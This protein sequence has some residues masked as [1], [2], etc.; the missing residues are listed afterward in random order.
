MTLRSALEA[1]EMIRDSLERDM[2]ESVNSDYATSAV[3]SRISTVWVPAKEVADRFGIT[4]ERLRKYRNGCP[5]LRRKI[6]AAKRKAKT[7]AGQLRDHWHYHVEDLAA[8]AESALPEPSAGW[9]T[10]GDAAMAVGVPGTTIREWARQGC[11][12]MGRKPHLRLTVGPDGRQVRLFE[13][14]DLKRELK[15]QKICEDGVWL[16]SSAAS[17]LLGVST[18]V[19]GR[20]RNFCP[21]LDRPLRHQKKAGPMSN[22]TVRPI[23]WYQSE[24]IQQLLDHLQA[25]ASPSILSSREVAI[26]FGFSAATLKKWRDSCPVLARPLHAERQNGGY[27]HWRYSRKDLLEISDAV[28]K[29][30][31]EWLFEA[32]ASK[33]LGIPATTIR[34]WGTYGCPPLGGRKIGTKTCWRQ[35]RAGGVVQCRT[36]SLRDLRTAREAATSSSLDWMPSGEVEAKYGYPTCSIEKWRSRCVWLKR[37]IRA[38]KRDGPMRGGRVRGVWHYAVDDLETVHEAQDQARRRAIELSSWLRTGEAVEKFKISSATLRKWDSFC[39]PLGRKIRSEVVLLTDAIGRE[40]PTRVFDPSDLRMACGERKL[41]NSVEVRR[42]ACDS[43]KPEVEH[44]P[45]KAMVVPDNFPPEIGPC[46]ARLEQHLAELVHLPEFEGLCSR[47]RSL[48]EKFFEEWPRKDEGTDLSRPEWACRKTL[49]DISQYKDPRLDNW[50]RVKDVAEGL[51]LQSPEVLR[52][53]ERGRLRDN[54]MTHRKRRIDPASV[55]EYC[56]AEGIAF[57]DV[58]EPREND[59]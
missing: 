25:K 59:L 48:L 47:A 28:Q 10:E 57:N 52:L 5:I 39:E 4:L 46:R 30:D 56:R 41:V 42:A 21:I 26:T 23:Y 35:T 19:L 7:S 29:E 3:D 9:L 6:R 37:P 54:G 38:M 43:T 11:P 55:F 44:V 32:D 18:A 8:I 45:L 27:R 17:Q 53:L 16:T 20:W 1:S 12:A 49:S 14:E 34:H 50:P 24:D 15:L 58:F 2:I 33:E 22:Q 40:L 31:S 36:Y 13:I 51:G